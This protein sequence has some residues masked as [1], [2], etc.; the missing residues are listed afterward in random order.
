MIEFFDKIPKLQLKTFASIKQKV[1][2]KTSNKE[3]ILKTDHKLFGHMLLVASSRKIEMK[4]VLQYP[5]GPLPWSL[6]NCDGTIKKTNKAAL[7]RKLEANVS[8]AEE[9]TQ[10]SASIIDGMSPIQKTNGDHMTFDEQ[11]SSI[12]GQ[13]IVP[14][15]YF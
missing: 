14:H 1:T 9:I 8:S 11:A 5:L 13:S 12:A 10:P 4:E 2:K 6:A 3:V 7:A 15:Q